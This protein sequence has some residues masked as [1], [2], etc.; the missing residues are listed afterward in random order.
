MA[1]HFGHESHARVDGP[2]SVNIPLSERWIQIGLTFIP[3]PYDL[4]SDRAKIKRT[5]MRLIDRARSPVEIDERAAKFFKAYREKAK[6]ER[7]TAP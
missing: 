5:L 7:L 3:I 6:K 2:D 1:R 4:L